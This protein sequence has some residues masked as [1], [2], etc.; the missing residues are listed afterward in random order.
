M[1]THPISEDE[2]DY[3][4]KTN[5]PVRRAALDD[6]TVRAA[7]VSIRGAVE[8][9]T[10]QQRSP[11]ATPQ[12]HLRR[13]WA[14]AG[15]TLGVIAAASLVG[16]E[17]TSGRSSSFPLAMQSAAAAQVDK[18][19]QAAANDSWPGAGQWLYVTF[20]DEETGVVTV[21]GTSV[22]YTQTKTQQNWVA[23]D[24]TVRNRIV[25]D[26]LSFPNQQAQAAYQANQA[27]F[28]SQ[29]GS[30]T[31]VLEDDVNPNDDAEQVW[32]T[33]PPTDP[34]TLLTEMWAYEL[35]GPAAESD[36]TSPALLADRPGYLWNTLVG[37]LFTTTP[38][39]QLA[40]TAYRALA[41]VPGV[42]V[43]GTQTD[44][45]GRSGVAISFDNQSG[46]Y[47]QTLIISQ[48]TGQLLQDQVTPTTTPSTD[49]G[50]PDSTQS[51]YVFLQRAIVASS[52]TLP[53]GGS[54]PLPQR[55]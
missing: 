50:P 29:V 4:L 26:G 20:K 35:A 15:A 43:L 47:E 44:S 39:S 22:Q 46:H 33:Q 8:A 16:I 45:L 18:L 32:E 38:S 5:D 12:R 7:L 3:R 6:E 27:A 41:Y 42:Q 55:R 19:A 28:D 40:V 31:G 48:S 36:P 25:G 14:V 21:G 34:Q 11:R 51:R 30:S 10:S 2:L 17:T 54:Q 37:T 13:R 23:P 24:R 1:D 53:D 9:R 52:T 49:G